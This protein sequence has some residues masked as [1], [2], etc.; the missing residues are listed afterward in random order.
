MEDSDGNLTRVAI[1]RRKQISGALMKDLLLTFN[2]SAGGAA[3]A[4]SGSM[5]GQRLVILSKH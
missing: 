5:L 3:I 2:S 1:M 4:G